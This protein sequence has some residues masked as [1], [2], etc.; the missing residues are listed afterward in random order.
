MAWHINYEVDRPPSTGMNSNVIG[1]MKDELGGKIWD[2][3]LLLNQ[4]HTLIQWIM[5]VSIKKAKGT[6]KCVYNKK[7]N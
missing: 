1:L 5:P 2:N 6:K 7:R 3:L 4:K